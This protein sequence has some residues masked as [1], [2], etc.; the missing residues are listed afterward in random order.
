MKV[1][2]V[3][4]SPNKK[5]CT[6]TALCEVEKELNK[7]DIETEIF[8]IGKKPIR[9]CTACAKC[10]D[11]G[12]CVFDDD[13]VNV[14][15]GIA[16]KSDGFIFGSPVHYAGPSGFITSFLD[17]C[18]Y[19]GSDVFTYKPGAAIVSCRRGG[20]TAAFEQLNKYFTINSMP[21]VSSQYWNMVHGNTPQ[22]VMQDM[23]GLQT[24]RTLGRNM[25]W[26]LKSIAAGKKAGIGLPEQ[27]ERVWTNFIR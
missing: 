18:F 10:L 16:D 19:A 1:L 9:G 26:L 24:M 8:Y 21:V 5:G 2:L 7:K 20:A 27:E 4:G 23:E 6:Y 22:E 15:L 3:N 12:K 13:V 17:R 25:A 11:L 14:A